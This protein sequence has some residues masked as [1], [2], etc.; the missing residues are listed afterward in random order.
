MTIEYTAEYTNNLQETRPQKQSKITHMQGI[1]KDQMCLQHLQ[2]NFGESSRS[3]AFFQPHEKQDQ[4][5]KGQE[6]E[7][8]RPEETE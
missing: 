2:H 1:I 8:E 3:L 5:T 7:H 6:I 4:D